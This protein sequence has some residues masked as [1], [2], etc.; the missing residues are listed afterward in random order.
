MSP[1]KLLGLPR[2]GELIILPGGG[3]APLR[4]SS[5]TLPAGPAEVKQRVQSKAHRLLRNLIALRKDGKKK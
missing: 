2:S 1:E 5:R 3:E 4:L